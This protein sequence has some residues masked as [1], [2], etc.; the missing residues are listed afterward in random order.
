MFL[1]KTPRKDPKNNLDTLN[2]RSTS[3]W[4][5]SSSNAFCKMEEKKQTN[6]NGMP[7]T[8]MLFNEQ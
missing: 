3:T 5:T 1:G 6:P 2:Y 8:L 7:K 4:Q